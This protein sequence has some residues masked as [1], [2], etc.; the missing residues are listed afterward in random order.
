MTVFRL[1]MALSAI[2]GP[3][4]ETSCRTEPP[5]ILL[6]VPVFIRPPEFPGTFPAIPDSTDQALIGRSWSTAHMKPANSRAIATTTLLRSLPRETRR[7]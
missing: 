3:E 2:A 4:I 1:E 6:F 7:R 5:R